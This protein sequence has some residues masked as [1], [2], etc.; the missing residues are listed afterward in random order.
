MHVLLYTQAH[1]SPPKAFVHV[2]FASDSYLLTTYTHIHT[3]IHP[4]MKY[5]RKE[6]MG[7]GRI[8]HIATTQKTERAL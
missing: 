1:P 4:Y 6:K 3:Y 8:T 7:E 2:V 5:A